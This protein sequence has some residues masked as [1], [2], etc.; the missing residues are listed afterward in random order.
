MFHN[1]GDW[2]ARSRWGGH[3]QYVDPYLGTYTVVK[4]DGDRNSQ[5]VA[6]LSKGP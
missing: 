2:Y 6:R 5:K 1:P 3:T 4:V